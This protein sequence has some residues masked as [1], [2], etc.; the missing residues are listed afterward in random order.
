MVVENE[1]FRV[2]EP[3]LLCDNA[4]VV[5]SGD[6][7][8]LDKCGLDGSLKIATDES[9]ALGDPLVRMR[10]VVMGGKDDDHAHDLDW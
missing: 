3:V 5:A 10:R 9:K 6:A 1:P 7:D 4:C 2:G 8:S